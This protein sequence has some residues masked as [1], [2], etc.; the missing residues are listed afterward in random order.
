VFRGLGNRYDVRGKEHMQ[1][2]RPY[3]LVCN[4]QSSLDIIGLPYCWPGQCTIMAKKMLKYVG[5]FGF[6]AWLCGLVFIDQANRDKARETMQKTADYINKKQLKMLIFPEGTRNHCKELKPFKKG[7]F[8][9]AIQAQLPI[10]P[11][12]MSNYNNFYSKQERI[13]E[14][15]NIIIQCL[16]AISTEGMTPA[17]VSTLSDQVFAAMSAVYPVISQ[18]VLDSQPPLHTRL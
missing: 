13:L 3:I 16:P 17:D 12:V 4:H 11:V 9:L 5:T 10:V 18:E 15:G 8:H 14:P 6:A 7:A 1:S 2:D